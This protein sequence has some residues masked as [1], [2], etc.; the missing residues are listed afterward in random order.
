MTTVPRCTQS[1][2]TK[3]TVWQKG[4][5]FMNVAAHTTVFISGYFFGT[6]PH[7]KCTELPKNFLVL[8]FSKSLERILCTVT[9]NRTLLTAHNRSCLPLGTLTGA[10]G[11]D[12]F[13]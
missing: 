9:I 12:N 6:P 5:S 7:L 4:E 1:R 8:H 11:T 2:S 13:V 3:G 10:F